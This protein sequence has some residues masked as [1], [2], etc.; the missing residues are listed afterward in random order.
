[1]KWKFQFLIENF[2]LILLWALQFEHARRR[3]VMCSAMENHI[4]LDLSCLFFSSSP[5]KCCVSARD[6]YYFLQERFSGH[7]KCKSI[8]YTFKMKKFNW[9][10]WNWVKINNRFCSTYGNDLSWVI[11]LF[12]IA[13]YHFQTVWISITLI[14]AYV[15]EDDLFATQVLR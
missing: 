9:T 10:H 7:S 8:V 11:F 14:H 6:F 2:S 3:S 4:H 15:C 12:R 13:H 1:M 5:I